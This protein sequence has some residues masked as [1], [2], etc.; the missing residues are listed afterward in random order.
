MN[1]ILKAA[2]FYFAIVFGVGFLCGPI[3][4]FWLEPNFGA[5]TAI[6]MEV[7]ILVMAMLFAARYV[8]RRLRLPA[9]W[10]AQA[11]MGAIA[12]FLVLIAD[13]A[14]GLLLRKL[15]LAEIMANFSTPTGRV[16]A[17]ALLLFALLPMLVNR[18]AV[19]GV[20]PK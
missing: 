5:L 9:M 10:S 2:L 19:Q 7:P 6:W 3:R 16:Y 17:G 14:V 13:L 12:L 18:R 8:P 15:T 20:I 4:L 1:L 11:G